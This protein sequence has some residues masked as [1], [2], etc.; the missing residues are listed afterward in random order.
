MRRVSFGHQRSSDNVEAPTKRHVV[1][2]VSK[3]YDPLATIVIKL[4]LFLQEICLAQ[5]GWDE[6]LPEGLTETWKTLI[7][8]LQRS[9]SIRL[10]RC[11]F[12]GLHENI[13]GYV[14]LE[15]PLRELTQ[16]LYICL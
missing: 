2:I 6:P 10:P 8:E 3:F 15:M 12:S 9:G 7:T 11:Y 14:D 13:F 1:S 16:E 5:I 4:K